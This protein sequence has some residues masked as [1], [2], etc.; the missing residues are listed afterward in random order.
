MLPHDAEACGGNRCG[1]CVDLAQ[2]I[3]FRPDWALEGTHAPAEQQEHARQA[4]GDSQG[5]GRT[6]YP[7]I[8]GVALGYDGSRRCV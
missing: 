1:G 4:E 8:S 6:V 7:G 5:S 2:A 3:I